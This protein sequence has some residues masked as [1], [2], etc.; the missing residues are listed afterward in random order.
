M[1]DRQTDRWFARRNQIHP[2]ED[3]KKKKKMEK[4]P[5]GKSHE[6]THRTR[7]RKT[8]RQTDRQTDSFKSIKQKKENSSPR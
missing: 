5:R 6:G 3:G 8:E 4:Q 1:T 2:I 7:E